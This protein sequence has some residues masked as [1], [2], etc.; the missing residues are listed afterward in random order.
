MN[1]KRISITLLLTAAAAL[2]L[3][4]LTASPPAHAAIG[5]D[6]PIPAAPSNLKAKAAGTT[7]VK[8]TWTNNAANQS[9]VVVSLNGVKSVD[10]P[11]ATVSSYTWKGLSPD[12]KYWF[13]IASKIYGTPGDPTGPGNTQSAWVGPAYA[14]T[15]TSSSTPCNFT[16]SLKTCKST[17]PTVSYTS[18]ATGDTSHCTFV[19]NITWGDGGSTTK[20][21]TDPTDG[22]HLMGDHKYAA[23][24]VYAIKVKVK[25]TAGTCTATSS[26]HAFTLL[27]PPLP[28]SG[29]IFYKNYAG[30]SAGPLTGTV[31]YVQANWIVPK[32]ECG[33]APGKNYTGRAAVW[34][35][36]WG[37]Q[38]PPAIPDGLWQAGTNSQCTKSGTK[39][40][41]QYYAWYELVPHNPQ[42]LKGITVHAGDK[43]FA[44]VYYAGED[45]GQ[46]K[47]WYNVTDQTSG[48]R[49]DGFIDAKGVSLSDI[50]AA[51][52]PEVEGMPGNGNLAKFAPIT[53]SNI[54]IG[55]SFS[56]Q[57]KLTQYQLGQ[58]TCVIVCVDDVLAA[59]GP[60]RNSSS[61]VTWRKYAL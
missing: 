29:S 54:A 52:G 37:P 42:T 58:Q 59:P 19:F 31:L 22:H 60:L 32:V 9:G 24:G 47:L 4:L 49:K 12:T 14:T 45:H 50:S 39:Q 15:A 61:T 23:P 56:S 8:L 6:T 48:V 18:N 11:G 30:Y 51:G 41:T 55:A 25:T 57:A 36:M 53:F 10:L 20:T 13:Y 38:A 27:A 5:S 43:I 1:L 34:V 44:Q 46:L 35:G 3:G 17:D 7:S 2:V 16:L 26:V 28:P 40:A 21:E 33:D